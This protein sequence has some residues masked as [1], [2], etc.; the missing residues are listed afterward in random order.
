MEQ[1]YNSSN[2]AKYIENNITVDLIHYWRPDEIVNSIKSITTIENIPLDLIIKLSEY[3]SE[4][5]QNAFSDMINNISVK[6]VKEC[7]IDN[8]HDFHNTKNKAI[9]EQFCKNW[10]VN[11]WILYTLLQS[12]DKHIFQ[13]ILKW[14]H[15]INGE[16]LELILTNRDL[17]TYLTSKWFWMA[18]LQ[19][20]KKKYNMKKNEIDHNNI[21]R[22]HTKWN[23]IVTKP[24]WT[25][26]WEALN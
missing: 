24:S 3:D 20:M 22:N 6:E 9:A 7:F 15:K 11:K 26:L 8:F 12:N 1:P 19:I 10:L 14:L 13:S 17:V 23:I 5:V 25:N 18:L 21:D 4:K 2:R 16:K